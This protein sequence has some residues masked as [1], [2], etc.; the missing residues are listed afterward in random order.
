MRESVSSS[1]S[2]K[3]GSSSTTSTFGCPR[4]RA[5]RIMCCLPLLPCRRIG[6]A[7]ERD[8]KVRA[9]TFRQQFERRAVGVSELSCD[10][11]AEAGAARPRR[12]EWLENLRPKLSRYA[13]SVVRQLAYYGITHVS[14]TYHDADAGIFFLAMLPR[15]PHQIPYDLVQVPASEDHDQLRRG[16]NRH[17]SGRDTL[18]LDD[19]LNQ[20]MHE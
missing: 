8:A 7:L 10:I 20:R 13:R 5:L 11:Q 15:I 1:S 14:G 3:S 4:S 17:A 12:E 9:R 6:R 18:G 2:S 19:F 16:L